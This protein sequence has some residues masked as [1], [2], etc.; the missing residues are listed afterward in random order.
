MPSEKR[1]RKKE[2]HRARLE[3]A[4]AE[5]RRRQ[6]R[7]QI[8]T[9]AVLIGGLFIVFAAVALLSDDD[10][11]PVAADTSTAA[12]YGE[13]ECAPE[14][15]PA[16]LPTSFDAAPRRCLDDGVD[17]SAVVTTSEGAF[18]VDLDEA[19]APVTVNNFVTLARWGW[20]DGEGFH[21][22][23]KDFMNQAGNA[24]G[25]GNP[26]YT[27]PDELPPSLDAYPKGTLAM[28]NRGPDTGGSQWFVCVDC[29]KLTSPAY[30]DFGAVTQGQE[31]VD[32]INALGVG[33]G[34]PSKPV[35]I[36]TVEIV[37]R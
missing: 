36:D 21:R 6:R 2:G 22:V 5:A 24:A 29:T 28:A 31:V 8:R 10:D 1:Q 23:V 13:G 33:D 27:I 9:A 16:V 30:A 18:T 17:Y 20:F 19:G 3:A 34:P 15:K 14:E 7:R 25:R 32:A 37:E 35:T 11:D 26:G 12:P 4:R